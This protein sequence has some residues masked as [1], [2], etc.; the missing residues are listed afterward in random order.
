[1]GGGGLGDVEDEIAAAIAVVADE[2]RAGRH[3]R[4]GANKRVRDTD[5]AQPLQQH[6]A[7]SIVTH[8]AGKDRPGADPRRLIDENAGRAA[9]EGADIRRRAKIAPVL[10]RADEFDQ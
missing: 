3:A 4:H 6:G 8:R 10:L 2:G 9:G 5:A 7:E 1:M